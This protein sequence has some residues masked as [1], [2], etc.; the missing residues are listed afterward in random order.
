M[1]AITFPPTSSQLNSGIICL[2][3]RPSLPHLPAIDQASTLLNNQTLSIPDELV[4]GLLHR[5]TKGVLGGSSKA[6]KSWILLDL[7]V[8]VATG[9]PFLQ[10]PTTQGRV[11]FINLEIKESF[12][13]GRL[14]ALAARKGLTTLNNLDTW[15]LRGRFTS[16]EALLPAIIDRVGQSNYSLIVLDLWRSCGG[17][18]QL[19][20]KGV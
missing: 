13:Q 4:Q 19:N 3:P 6:G 16:A 12:F 20:L 5:S 10:W 17:C 11:L 18:K 1:S 8:S 9:T 7:A 2:R 14:Q 15:S